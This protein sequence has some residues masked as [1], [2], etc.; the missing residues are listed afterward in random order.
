MIPRRGARDSRD[1]RDGCRKDQRTGCRDDEHRECGSRAAR[2]QPPG[3]GSRERHGQEDR[4]SPIREAHRRSA[5][6]LGRLHEA[7]DLGVRRRAR[8]TKRT[9]THGIA[10]DARAA[11][12]LAPGGVRAREALA[13]QSRLV[14]RRRAIEHDGVDGNQ[15]TVLDEEHI[16]RGDETRG[17]I[18]QQSID[19]FPVCDGRRSFDE[20]PELPA[21][22]SEGSGVEIV[23]SREHQRDHRARE[24]LA[25][26][27][28][29]GD[30]EKGDHVGAGLPPS[31]PSCH[32]AHQGHADDEQRGGPDAVCR[33]LLS[34]EPRDSADQ[35]GG[36]DAGRQQRRPARTFGA[37]RRLRGS[38][39]HLRTVAVP[40]R[41]RIGVRALRAA[42][43][44]ACWTKRRARRRM[45]RWWRC[46]CVGRSRSGARS[47]A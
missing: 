38:A 15:L 33:P 2:D 23:T 10:G 28:C 17:D 12:H 40:I 21:R 16:A 22:S 1:E 44:Y 20:G 3:A 24:V 29:A 37:E 6:G 46:S 18:R 43:N 8:G 26:R 31:D 35:E 25:E 41:E 5:V 13:G 34:Y 36:R 4:C 39:R 19:A 11:S 30:R 14:E 9:Q 45:W 47:N 32:R 42:V 27:E 7:H